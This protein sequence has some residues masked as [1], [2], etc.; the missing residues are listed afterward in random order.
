M[1]GSHRSQSLQRCG[2]NASCECSP[3]Q[4]L[5]EEKRGQSAEVQ[6]SAS[7]AHRDRGGATGSSPGTVND[8]RNV[9]RTV[10]GDIRTMSI[11]PTWTRA[12]TDP[13]LV[14][15]TTVIRDHLS[16]IAPTDPQQAG[17]AENLHMLEAEA[18]RRSAAQ[19]LAGLT[20][21]PHAPRPPGLPDGGFA[22]V[23]LPDVPAEVL[24]LVP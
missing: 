13:E 7:E 5:E 3:E 16:T 12:L 1:L 24:N 23:E 2:A 19:T 8:M 18:E 22:L 21:G 11:S 17:A 10:T 9:Q 14:Q 20:L 6:R 15:Q 4:R